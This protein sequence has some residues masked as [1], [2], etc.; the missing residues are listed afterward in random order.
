VFTAA[1]RLTL[2]EARG[3]AI[4][5]T[6]DGQ[7]LDVTGPPMIVEAALPMIR[8]HK[9]AIVAHLQMASA[10]SYDAPAELFTMRYEP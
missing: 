8:Q 9:A 5:L 3:V 4:S 10:P 2:L 1:D 7:R 6:P